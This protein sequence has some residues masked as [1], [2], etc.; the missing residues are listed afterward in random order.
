MVGGGSAERCKGEEDSR[1]E[2]QRK[3]EKRRG[4]KQQVTPEQ[5]LKRM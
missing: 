3:T 4:E 5:S 1:R 2:K